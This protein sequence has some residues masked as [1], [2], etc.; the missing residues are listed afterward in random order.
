MSYRVAR[1]D[2]AVPIFADLISHRGPPHCNESR[3]QRHPFGK[4]ARYR[5]ASAAAGRIA[6]G[7]CGARKALAE[8]LVQDLANA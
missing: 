7:R 3:A 2:Q 5:P 4:R 1:K 6:C 8:G